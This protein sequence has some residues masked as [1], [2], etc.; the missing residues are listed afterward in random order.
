MTDQNNIETAKLLISR[1]ER[2][3]V[4]SYWAHRA[5]GIRGALIRFVE[6]ADSD[7]ANK[8][9]SNQ[10]STLEKLL[11]SGYFLLEKAAREI[12]G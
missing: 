12:P 3:S 2:L 11:K 8:N 7:N 10:S 6:N 5:S 9:N 4:D 1:L